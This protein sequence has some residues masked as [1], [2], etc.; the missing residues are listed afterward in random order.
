LGFFLNP[1][2]DHDHIV[3]CHCVAGM[4]HL[5]QNEERKMKSYAN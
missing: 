5:E 4:P 1:N 2:P 3:V